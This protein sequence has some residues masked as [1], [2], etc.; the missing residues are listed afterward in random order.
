MISMKNKP[1][2]DIF[3]Q[4]CGYPL[5]GDENFCPYCGQK[6]NIRP[7]SIKNYVHNLLNNFLNFDNR[8]WQTII[9]LIKYPAKV[10]LDYIQGKRVRYSNPFRFLVQISIVYFLLS[11][12][13]D[14][15]FQIDNRG[16]IRIKEAKEKS[17]T[18]NEIKNIFF[19]KLDSIDRQKHFTELLDKPE[20]TLQQKDSIVQNLLQQKNLRMLIPERY[21]EYDQ[22]NLEMET[23]WAPSFMASYIKNKNISYTYYPRLV[24]NKQT[25]EKL[26]VFNKILK[27]FGLVDQY[28]YNEMNEKEIIHHL[29]IQNNLRN[30]IA[31]LVPQRIMMLLKKPESRDAYKRAITSKITL[32]LFFV[33]P[34][35]GLF[36]YLLYY[37]QGYSYTETLVFIFYLQSIYFII[38][39]IELLF[40]LLPDG[41][42]LI[43]SLL[44]EFWFIYFLINNFKAFYRQKSWLNMFKVILL[45]IPVYLILTGIGLTIISVLSLIIN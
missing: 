19:R 1:L 26:S 24:D 40:I 7:L 6:N 17:K 45:V 2:K 32:G 44:A 23:A 41:I 25:F 8:I 11:G 38:L 36:V 15:F 5:R 39:L 42:N 27:L 10:P 12:V 13:I 43:V 35:Y 33:L 21:L 9:H 29:G 37:K 31:I 30:K 18:Q 28:P 34:L 22:G 20:L 16:F 3:C 14:R 4:N